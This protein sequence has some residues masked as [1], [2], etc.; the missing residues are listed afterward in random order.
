MFVWLLQVSLTSTHSVCFHLCCGYSSRCVPGFS[1]AH[2]SALRC[3][4]SLLSSCCA[5]AVSAV[6]VVT[7]V[8]GGPADA[9]GI[10]AGD[11][12]AAVG[13][14]ST[15]GLSLYEA[16]DLLQARGY[17]AVCQTACQS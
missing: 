9:A 3:A 8:P 6:Q 4:I 12:I 10:T 2:L 17:R 14:T 7:P 1:H 16:S 5:A 11:V 15:R 13:G